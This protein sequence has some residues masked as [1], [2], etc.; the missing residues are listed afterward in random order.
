MA[1]SIREQILQ[2][3]GT[4]LAAVAS[5]HAATYLRSPTAPLTPEQTPALLL[6]PESDTI[7]NRTEERVQR[8]LT[9]SIVAVARQAGTTGQPAD[10]AADTLLVAAH[11]AL[12]PKPPFSTLWSRID[13]ADTDWH[14]E[15]MNVSASWQPARYVITYLTKRHDIATKG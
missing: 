9:I 1:T 6:L 7:E 4:T 12:F 3:I 11:A 13:P 14:S 2:A 10:Q 8:K 15:S 5:A